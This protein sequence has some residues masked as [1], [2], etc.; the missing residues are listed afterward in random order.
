MYYEFIKFIGYLL[1]TTLLLCY[2]PWKSQKLTRL[3][4]TNN[5]LKHP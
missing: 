1:S 2:E 5:N 3:G 4:V